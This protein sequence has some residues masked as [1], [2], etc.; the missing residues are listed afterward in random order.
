MILYPFLMLVFIGVIYITGLMLLRNSQDLVILWGNSVTIETSTF[1]LVF[2]LLATFIIGYC[3]LMVLS[4]VFSMPRRVA[5]AREQKRLTQAQNQLNSGLVSLVE[6][7]WDQAEKALVASV[8]D[9][10]TPLLNYLGAARA[11][12]MKQNY[13]KRDEYLK[14]ASAY[15]EEAEIAVAVSQAAMQME[16]EQIEQARATLIHLRELSP[17]HPYPNQLLAKVYLL[18]EDWRQL[19]Q[20]V[21]ELVA[22]NPAGTDEYVPYMQ[23]AVTGLFESTAGKQDLPALEAI[24]KH[25]PEVLQAETYALEAYCKALTN[26]G[27]GD[28]AAP[29]LEARIDQQPQRDLVACYGRIQH[30]YPEQAL[31]HAKQWHPA[32]AGDPEYMLCMARLSQQ[33]KAMAAS[34][35]Y[36][37]QALG[38]APNKRVYYEFAELLWKMGDTENS[39]RCNRQGLR[40]CVQ[41]KARPFKRD[42]KRGVALSEKP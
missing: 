17:E 10:E 35:D 14:A 19:A 27:G 37:E 1:A 12:H 38:L 2:G 41:G 30:R 13:L 40:Y 20:L 8:Y 22:S 28:L 24:W 6:G 21:P 29:L 31:T 16:S 34:A 33:C 26:A 42:L 15:G 4:W 9:S 39:A 18:Q 36:Y 25:F 11:A 23:R 7:H 5:K 3:A 32:M